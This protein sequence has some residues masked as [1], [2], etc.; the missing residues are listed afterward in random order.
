MHS[1]FQLFYHQVYDETL[2]EEGGFL[3]CRHGTYGD[4]THVS[5][6][7]PGDLD[8]SFA[9]HGEETTDG[10]E[11]Y[12]AVGGL[13]AS[14][15][16][17]LSL[18]PSG[19][20]FYGADTGGYKHSPPDKELFTRWFEQTALSTVMQIGNSASTVAWEP[21]PKTGYDA[22]MLDWYRTYTRLHLRLFPY[23]WTYAKRLATDGRPIQRALGLAYPELG[24]HP[25]DTYLL[26]DDLLVAPVLERGVTKRDVTFPPGRWI[27]W[28]TGE[29]HDGGSTESVDAPLET[30]P[31]FVR[32]GSIVPMLRPTIDAIGPTTEPDRVDSYATT[33]GVLWARVAIGAASS[34]ELFDGTVV[35]QAEQGGGA[36]L[37]YA[38]GSELDS[39]AIFELVGT[40]APAAVSESGRLLAELATL[41]ELEAAESGWT[42]VADTGGTTFVKVAAGKHEIEVEP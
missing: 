12:R 31:L 27:D 20:P 19:F 11:T 9:K 21:D 3:L 10:S 2:P 36:T 26:G 15:V 23:V 7:W 30:L 29:A 14:V 38:P 39:G 1:R 40:R 8:A 16:A 24:V 37:S 5:V 35:E 17:G 22:E 25:N 13:P 6:I 18:G 32:E 33:P 42:W 34:F 4:Q 41:A 28:W